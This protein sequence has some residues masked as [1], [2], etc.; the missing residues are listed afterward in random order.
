MVIQ[1]GRAC[2]GPG[3]RSPVKAESVLWEQAF[4][5]QWALG[6]C[7]WHPG[8]LGPCKLPLR[9]GRYGNRV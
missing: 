5:F 6:Y 7:E 1:G 4:L 3:T 9:T 2:R 8:C